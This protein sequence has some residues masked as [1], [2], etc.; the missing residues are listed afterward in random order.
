MDE[1]KRDYVVEAASL[2]VCMISIL[3]G[4]IALQLPACIPHNSSW[5]PMNLY[6][7]G[8]ITVV[9][10]YETNTFL[11]M[12]IHELRRVYCYKKNITFD[13][14]Y[15]SLKMKAAG[16]ISNYI[17]LG[18]VIVLPFMSGKE[19]NPITIIVPAII[20]IRHICKWTIK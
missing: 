3:Y 16:I 10:S 18:L 8:I 13:E 20:F 9:I 14:K 19:V 11:T 4:A 17:F 15:V 2:L 7:M 1:K 5:Y 12:L 6:F